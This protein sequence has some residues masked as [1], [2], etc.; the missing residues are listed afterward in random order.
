MKDH[1]FRLL[2]LGVVLAHH[3]L[4]LTSREQVVNYLA[5][6]LDELLSTFG[7]LVR[8]LALVDDE[9]S[10]SLV[11]DAV[12]LVIKDHL[13]YLLLNNSLFHGN[14]LGDVGDLDAA[15]G[16]D[17]AEE[18]GLQKL[19]VKDVEVVLDEQI[20]LELVGVLGGGGLKEGKVTLGS[21]VSDCRH[22]LNVDSGV[23]YALLPSDKAREFGICLVGL[24]SRDALG[25]EL[26]G[27]A[28]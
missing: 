16:F 7:G 14:E 2:Q 1:L 19:L 13:R 23:F 9:L 20:R 26:E 28:K 18:V 11:E 4:L 15:E 21:G 22:G 8:H 12:E 10:L 17:E 6:V 27:L 25:G 24:H 5:H 3:E